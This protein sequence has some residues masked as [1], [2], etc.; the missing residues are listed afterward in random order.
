MEKSTTFN[1]GPKDKGFTVGE[2]ILVLG[3]IIIVG[4]I[5]NASQ[6]QEKNIEE[7]NLLNLQTREHLI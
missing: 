7:S 2:L 3:A 4:L 6:N 1:M 5:W